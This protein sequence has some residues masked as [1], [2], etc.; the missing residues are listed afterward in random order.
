MS[1]LAKEADVVIIGGG[2]IGCAAAYHLARR[3][4]KAVLVEKGDISG[5]GSGTTFGVVR[6]VGRD[7]VEIPLQLKS[8]EMWQNLSAEL[9]CEVG[10]RQGGCLYLAETETD[11]APLEQYHER[12]RQG[13]VL[14]CRMVGPGEVKRLIPPL[15][16]PMKG[17]LYSPR[18]GFA[19]RLVPARG[20][21]SAAGKLGAQI[22]TETLCV[23][24][25]VSGGRVSGVITN[26]GEVRAH[27]VVNAAGVYAHRVASMVGFHMPLK[28]IR[29]T[30]CETEPLGRPLFK[31][32]FMG[33]GVM[34]LQ[35]IRG[36]VIAGGGK[37]DHDLGL[38]DLND[39]RAWL[40]HLRA[41]RK[42]MNLRLDTGHLKREF[43]RV[44]GPSFESRRKAAFPTLEAKA[45]IKRAEKSF[46]RLQELMPSLKAARIASIWAGLVGFTPD[47]L[48]LIGELDN[49]RGLV[50]AAGWSG[51]GYALGPA[52]GHLLSELIVDGRTSLSIGAF[53]PGRFAEGKV[54]KPPSSVFLSDKVAT[55][56]DTDQ[57]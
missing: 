7:P 22:H 17:A 44:F 2:L 38:D 32:W 42:I 25:E 24:I 29:T 41:F 26:K 50:M 35:T 43:V 5:E 45:T 56:T 46:Q 47:M 27:T 19:E 23:G 36:T 53:R 9:D 39:L 54:A 52:V 18:D 31:P 8:T 14:D 16:R 34:A 11:L 15:E 21:A 13:G 40:P 12:S 30:E 10:F 48:P 49:P 33:P 37:V 6:I 20:F 51:H 1:I 55:E 57:P 3:G 4:V 28:I